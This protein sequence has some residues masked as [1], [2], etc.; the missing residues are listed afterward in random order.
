MYDQTPG[1]GLPKPHTS[2]PTKQAMPKRPSR[3]T[4]AAKR[5]NA[6]VDR[7]EYEKFYD[8]GKKPRGIRVAKKR[9]MGMFNEGDF[10][11]R[12]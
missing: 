8:D 11:N 1:S 2:Q 10:G 5:A 3:F 12:W 6:K 7:S 4:K 9:A